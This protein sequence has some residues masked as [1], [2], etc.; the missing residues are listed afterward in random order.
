MNLTTPIISEDKVAQQYVAAKFSTADTEVDLTPSSHHATHNPT[1]Q[2]TVD[3]GKDSRNNRMCEER[4]QTGEAKRL[5]LMHDTL[6]G[7]E[8][9][10]PPVKN[11]KRVK[12]M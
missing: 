2:S 1:V 7:S 12:A 9:H 3:N 6:K 5:A 4:V 10:E 8:G 11:S